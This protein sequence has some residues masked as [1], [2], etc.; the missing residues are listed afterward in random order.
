M[1]THG[2]PFDRADRLLTTNAGEERKRE[3][4]KGHLGEVSEWT[5]SSGEADAPDLMN[6]VISSTVTSHRK[7]GGRRRREVESDQDLLDRHE[8]IKPSMQ[9]SRRLQQ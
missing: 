9:R 1:A 5:F 8:V 3:G 7:A 2:D 4:E 6:M